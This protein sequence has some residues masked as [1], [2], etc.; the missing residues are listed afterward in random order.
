MY[1]RFD[2]RVRATADAIM[3]NP[4]IASRYAPTVATTVSLRALR[5]EF[6]RDDR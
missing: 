1:L 4:T 6:Q 3:P 5:S 2:A